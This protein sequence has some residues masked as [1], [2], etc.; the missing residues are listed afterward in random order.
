MHSDPVESIM[1]SN[2]KLQDMIIES[3]RDFLK[4]LGAISAMLVVGRNGL[5][6]FAAGGSTP[7]EL[8]VIGDSVIWGQ[9]LPEKDKFYTHTANWLR[10]EAFGKS[11][12]VN[13]KVKAHSGSTLKFHPDEA[14][15]YKKA[16]RDETYY[17]KPE[18]NVGFPSSYKQIEVAADEYRNAG[19]Q[20]A[21]LIM[22]CGGITDIST[23][24]VYNPKGNDDE[25][26]RLIKQYCRDHMFEVLELAVSKNPNAKLA[27]IGYFPAIT[28][29]TLS[30]KILND[31]QEALGVGGFKKALTNN[32]I[33]RPLFFNKLR[34][35]AIV[36]S[37][38]WCEESDKNLREAV[39]MI[40]AKYGHNRAVFVK[41]PLTEDNAAEAPD[42]KLF[43]MGKGGVVNDPMAW[44]RI[45]DCREAL[46]VLK[47]DTGIDYPVR[48]CEIAAVGHPDPAG[49]RAYA[50]A[51]KT[52]VG[53]LLKETN[54]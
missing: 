22:I 40:N 34:K 54:R 13:L 25:L 7:F 46:P 43:T 41:S 24:Q 29:K 45:K 2:V 5:T 18:V 35:R 47:R 12:E 9:G 16:G 10:N 33:V 11:R 52:A 21:D 30:S 28:S 26:R 32:P 39:V 53:P 8:L 31:W 38:I 27:V 51:I 4:R 6:I 15:K 14:E 44:E 1:P 48:L 42:T 23:S 50:E 20:G 36:R 37:A 17:Y 19:K 3:R 49:A